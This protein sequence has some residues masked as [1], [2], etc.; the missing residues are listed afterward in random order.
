MTWSQRYAAEMCS[1]HGWPKL[2]CPN[3]S[4]SEKHLISEV[5]RPEGKT[6]G[7]EHSKSRELGDFLFGEE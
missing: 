5:D 6:I 4:E 1:C 3:T 7:Q 2:Q